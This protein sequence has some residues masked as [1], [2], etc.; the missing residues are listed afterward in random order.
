MKNDYDKLGIKFDDSL[1][2][3]TNKTGGYLHPDT[4]CERLRKFK[5]KHVLKNSEIKP[6][7]FRHNYATQLL[8]QGE[9]PYA[10]AKDMG[11]YSP[12]MTFNFYADAI[13]IGKRKNLSQS[14]YSLYK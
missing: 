13:E 2:M 10:V 1:M 14:L 3:F 11:H 9:S 7:K 8:E 5:T 12:T 4:F 6:L